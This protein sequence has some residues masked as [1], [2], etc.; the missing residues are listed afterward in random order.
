MNREAAQASPYWRSQAEVA[1]AIAS[2]ASSMTVVLDFDETLFLRNSTE[3]YLRSIA[4]RW[5]AVLVLVA[6]SILRPWQWFPGIP[7]GEQSRDWVRV[8]VLTSLF[9]GSCKRWEQIA[10][11][12]GRELSNRELLQ[13]LGRSE[14][15]NIVVASIGYDFILRP[16]LKGMKIGEHKLVSCRFRTGLRDRERGKLAL[17]SDELEKGWHERAILVTD[18]LDDLPVLE[19]VAGPYLTHWPQARYD[20]AMMGVYFPFYYT[21]RVKHP[22]EKY[23]IKT[24]A[25]EDWMFAILATSWLSPQ[26]VLHAVAVAFLTAS[27]WCVYEIGYMENDLVA[28][29]LESDGKLSKN[30]EHGKDMIN[31]AKPWA[32]AVVFA[33]PGLLLLA[34]VEDQGA[35]WLL[36]MSFLMWGLV[37]VGIR[38]VFYLYN[39]VNKF[40]RIWLYPVLQA[41]K[42]FGI[43]VV[44]S[45]NLVG[46]SLLISQIIARWVLYL[47]Y[48]YSGKWITIGQVLRF[49]F[50]IILILGMLLGGTTLTGQLLTFQT[51]AILTYAALKARREIMSIFSGFGVISSS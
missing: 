20:S 40:T 39:R 37:L 41:F 24:V 35:W 17:L 33:L 1:D 51:L 9:R 3:E 48:R 4:P 46:V 13:A 29:L 16:L 7:R 8:Y 31:L 10:P 6:L 47:I 5:L 50:F 19:K 22:G 38:L 21:T 15:R 25:A 43:L 49:I 18:S 45:T 36:A 42:S 30:Y 12:I 11:E 26:P 34:L 14:S 23:L 28:E 2:A 32:W 44:T 27:L